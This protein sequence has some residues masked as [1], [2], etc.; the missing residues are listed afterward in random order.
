MLF[1]LFNFFFFKANINQTIDSSVRDCE[2]SLFVFDDADY[3]PQGIFEELN[4]FRN[5][6]GGLKYGYGVIA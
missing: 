5:I 3:F 1:S 4:V 2:R 6:D